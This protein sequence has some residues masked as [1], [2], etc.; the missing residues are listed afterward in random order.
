[1]T[2]LLLKM[3]FYIYHTNEDGIYPTKGE[4]EGWAKSHGNIRTWLQTNKDGR[5]IFYT[6]HP[7]HTPV[8]ATHPISIPFYWSQMGDIITLA[9]MY[10]K[11]IASLQKN[12]CHRDWVDKM[13]TY[14]H[15]RCECYPFFLFFSANN[16]SLN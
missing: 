7:G 5:Y 13:T 12:T 10:L 8:T 1:M 2:L 11:E 3:S 16:S 9:I 6:S 14:H 15:S 4:E